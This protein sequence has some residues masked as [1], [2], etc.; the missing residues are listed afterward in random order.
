[1]LFWHVPVLQILQ[2]LL[3]KPCLKGAWDWDSAPCFTRNGE[4][5]Y[6]GFNS[7][8][9]ARDLMRDDQDAVLLSVV[10]GSDGTPTGNL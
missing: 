5:V 8:D 2:Q 9:W 1:M 3:M 6:G 4:R 10:F 7:G